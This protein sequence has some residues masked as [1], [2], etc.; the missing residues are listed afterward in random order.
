MRVVAVVPLNIHARSGCDVNFNRL[1]I[2]DRHYFQ[3]RTFISA[4]LVPG[5]RVA[6]AQDLLSQRSFHRKRFMG[7]KKSA[8]CSK[9]IL[10]AKYFWVQ[11]P[12]Q[13]CG[14]G[15]SGRAAQPA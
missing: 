14:N 10:Q 4:I 8:K 13:S 6:A 3:Y 12:D 1:G 5:G 9:T 11:N 2:D 7:G 15:F